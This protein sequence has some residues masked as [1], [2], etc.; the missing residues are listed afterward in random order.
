MRIAL[1]QLSEN[2]AEI[3]RAMEAGEE[4]ALT[5]DG[6]PVADI[7]ARARPRWIAGGWLEKRLRTSAADP[8]LVDELER[9]SG[10]RLAESR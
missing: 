8:A 4:V 6:A 2:G 3:L 1:E 10:H 7:V 9:L 5:R